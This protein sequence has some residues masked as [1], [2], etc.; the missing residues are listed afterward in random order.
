MRINEPPPVS[1]FDTLLEQLVE[2]CLV[3]SRQRLLRAP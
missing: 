1:S 3:M 2:L